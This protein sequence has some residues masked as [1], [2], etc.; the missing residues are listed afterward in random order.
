MFPIVSRLGRELA[1]PSTGPL[2]PMCRP[3]E[4][5]VPEEVV[6]PAA[7]AI[8]DSTDGMHCDLSI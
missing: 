1:D 5:S 2:A 6:V 8:D 4:L 3:S 7:E